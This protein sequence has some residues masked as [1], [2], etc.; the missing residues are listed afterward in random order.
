MLNSRR[1]L[2]R[3]Q[4]STCEMRPCEMLPLLRRRRPCEILL[5]LRLPERSRLSGTR[6]P[7]RRVY[8]KLYLLAKSSVDIGEQGVNALM[9]TLNRCARPCNCRR[10]AKT[11]IVTT[12]MTASF[13]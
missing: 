1:G 4:L 13:C 5:R 6:L 12:D 10:L 7:L 3:R 9:V 2:T 11:F 8:L